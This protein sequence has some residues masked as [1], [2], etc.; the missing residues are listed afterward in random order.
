[1]SSFPIF[2]SHES[3]FKKLL[4]A[5]RKG[6]FR[7]CFTLT[8]TCLLHE[9]LLIPILIS[10]ILQTSAVLQQRVTN[11]LCLYNLYFSS[12][13]PMLQQLWLLLHSCWLGAPTALYPQ[14]LLWEIKATIAFSSLLRCFCTLYFKWHKRFCLFFFPHKCA[15]CQPWQSFLFSTLY[16]C[17]GN[18]YSVANLRDF[19]CISFRKVEFWNTLPILSKRC[20]LLKNKGFFFK[21]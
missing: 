18:N 4:S 14:L 16:N 15:F 5:N 21:P 12:K 10:N 8:F 1:M 9:V 17:L 13:F 11:W 19:R 2:R 6:T 3:I 7:T 20:E